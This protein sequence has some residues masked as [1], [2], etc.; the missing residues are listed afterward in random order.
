ME[1]GVGQYVVP[2][3]GHLGTL[4]YNNFSRHGNRCGGV[5]AASSNNNECGVGVA[6]NANLG[7]TG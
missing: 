7:G 4:T 6:F 1:C 2:Y 5:I 3:F